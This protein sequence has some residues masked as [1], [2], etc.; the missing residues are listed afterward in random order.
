MTRLSKTE[1]FSTE[2]PQCPYC[3]RQFTAD[4]SFYYDEGRYDQEECD[5]CGHK[6]K[7]NVCNSTTWS[8]EAIADKEPS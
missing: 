5:N 6:F 1:T 8:C 7:V 2:G 4:E 3:E